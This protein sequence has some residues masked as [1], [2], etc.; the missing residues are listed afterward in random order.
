MQLYKLLWVK[1]VVDFLGNAFDLVLILHNEGRG[2]SFKE[3]ENALK[4]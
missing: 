4:R 1:S 3:K 2:R